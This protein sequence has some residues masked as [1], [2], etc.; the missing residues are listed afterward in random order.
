MEDEVVDR[1]FRYHPDNDDREVEYWFSRRS[2][3]HEDSSPERPPSP[4]PQDSSDDE[5]Y[6]GLE[7][8][9][10]CGPVPEYVQ[11]LGKL[12][13]DIP[14]WE[15]HNASDHPSER[16]AA[17]SG[18][19]TPTFSPDRAIFERER[20]LE[21]ARQRVSTKRSRLRRRCGI[22]NSQV[23]ASSSASALQL[24]YPETIFSPQAFSHFRHTFEAACQDSDADEGRQRKVL[25]RQLQEQ[26]NA[27]LQR[28][29]SDWNATHILD[30]FENQIQADAA[31]KQQA[32]AGDESMNGQDQRNAQP[33]HDNQP[34]ADQSPVSR[35]QPTMI[36]RTTLPAPNIYEGQQQRNEYTKF[37]NRTREYDYLFSIL[38]ED[39]KAYVIARDSKYTLLNVLQLVRQYVKENGRG[40]QWKSDLPPYDVS[41]QPERQRMFDQVMDELI[42]AVNNAEN[43]QQRQA[44]KQAVNRNAPS[45]SDSGHCGEVSDTDTHD[46]MPMLISPD[47]APASDSKDGTEQQPTPEHRDSPSAETDI[48]QVKLNARRRPK[49]AKVN[50]EVMKQQTEKLRLKR[51]MQRIRRCERQLQECAKETETFSNTTPQPVMVNRIIAVEAPPTHA[52]S[53]SRGSKRRHQARQCQSCV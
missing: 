3:E 34:P 27:A 45:E 41:Y 33:T 44:A 12:C 49:K 23:D 30:H 17:A 19:V 39:C 25:I 47:S 6:A 20:I 11:L 14:Y 15:Q 53:E 43:D 37:A 40:T 1:A 8:K 31:V 16:S 46:S 21:E 35:G 22:D 13:E 7:E 18:Y 5:S 42:G 29:P 50:A 38:N 52:T 4:P 2:S 26:T 48:K 51:L 9:N 32:L 36:L 28:I 24:D 10:T